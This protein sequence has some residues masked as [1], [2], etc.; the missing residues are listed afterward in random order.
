MLIDNNI[1]KNSSKIKKSHTDSHT[2]VVANK[3]G[4]QVKPEN[5]CY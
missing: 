1:M 3:K 4:F 2:G 5:P